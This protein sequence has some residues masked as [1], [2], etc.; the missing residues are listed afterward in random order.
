MKKFNFPLQKVLQLRKFKEEECKL[1]LGQAISVLNM[2]EKE[3]KENAARQQSA[4][5]QRFA[6]AS[7]FASWDIYIVRL[8]QEAQK[9]MEKAAQAEL[10]VEEKRQQ[11]LEASREV[12]AIEKLKEKRESEYRKAVLDYQMAEIDELFAARR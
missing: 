8:E 1:A 4:A 2:I 9:L 5:S 11:Y 6:D 12:K 3:I 7:Q 10:V